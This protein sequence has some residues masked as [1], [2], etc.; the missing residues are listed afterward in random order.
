MWNIPTAKVKQVTSQEAS[1]LCTSQGTGNRNVPSFGLRTLIL[2]AVH[3]SGL[4]A[5]RGF[6]E[7]S[8]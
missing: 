7:G 5:V 3:D 4:R 1:G 6:A 8:A 2:F